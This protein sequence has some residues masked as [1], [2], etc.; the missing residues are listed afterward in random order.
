MFLLVLLMWQMMHHQLVG[1]HIYIEIHTIS[2]I[3]GASF[4]ILGLSLEETLTV[5]AASAVLP[6]L[7]TIPSALS[8]VT[9]LLF[10]KV[11]KEQSFFY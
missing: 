4:A 8:I 11:F 5:P 1:N 10:L 6:L 7:S 9:T 2:D 3:R